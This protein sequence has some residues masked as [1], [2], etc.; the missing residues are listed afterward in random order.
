MG[1]LKGQAVYRLYHEGIKKHLYTTSTTERDTLRSRGWSYEGVV[2]RSN[3]NREVYR[4]YHPGIK[5]HHY[6]SDRNERDTLVRSGWKNE[7]VAWR[8][9]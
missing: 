5:T 2:W 7:G 1:K 8:V 9:E 4:L 3:G 6:T